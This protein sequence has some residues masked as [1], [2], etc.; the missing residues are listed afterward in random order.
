MILQEEKV[1]IVEPEK[2]ANTQL[3]KVPQQPVKQL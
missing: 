2:K 3:E 1:E